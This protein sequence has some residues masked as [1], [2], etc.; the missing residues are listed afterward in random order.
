MSFLQVVPPIRRT[1]Y[2]LH[3]KRIPVLL[4]KR[5]TQ[6]YTRK[7]VKDL[8]KTRLRFKPGS[9][10]LQIKHITTLPLIPSSK[11]SLFKNVKNVIC[12]AKCTKFPCNK[13]LLYFL[14][15]I[16]AK[17][18]LF[19]H[20][21]TMLGEFH[22]YQNKCSKPLIHETLKN[23]SIPTHLHLLCTV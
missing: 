22:S 21:Y 11:M 14:G 7:I 20:H 13:Y 16:P 8:Q 15:D 1:D 18:S 6:L 5:K 23:Y 4:S 9:I 10:S 12:T 3:W 17:F 2:I 19:G